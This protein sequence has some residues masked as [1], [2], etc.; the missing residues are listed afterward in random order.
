MHGTI[1]HFKNIKKY[2]ANKDHFIIIGPYSHET[3]PE[4]GLDYL[5][6]KP[7]KNL[8]DLVLEDNA[9]LSGLNITR[10]FYDWCLK[11]GPKPEWSPAKIY[12]TGENK[13]IETSDYLENEYEDKY[14]YLKSTNS[15]NSINGDGELDLDQPRN[16]S[17]TFDYDPD[18]P[19]MSN[20]S[21]NVRYPVDMNFYLNRTD[22]LV[23]TSPKIKQAFN[24]FG[25]VKLELTFSSN[26][27]DTDFVAFLMD[28]D[29]YGNSIK[30]GS[31]DANQLRT[32]YRHGYDKEILMEPNKIYNLTIDMYEIGHQ[33]LPGHRVR[34]AITSSFFPIVSRNL[35]TGND[36]AFDM[37]PG[38]KS[39]QT[40][41]YGSPLNGMNSRIHFRSNNLFKNSFEI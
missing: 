18:K 23:Y 4:G 27:K 2:G 34:L 35:N 5:T 32:R 12:I 31:M 38:V 1:M 37:H 21:K 8:G 13:W 41:Y 26:V 7:I 9:F 6:H 28:V 22:F 10:E 25:E 16:G 33:F 24:I 39:K 20:L 17:D 19:V 3:A 30:I 36:I 11:D 14:L 40:I 15:A 29:E